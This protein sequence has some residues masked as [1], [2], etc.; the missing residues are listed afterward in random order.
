MRLS[1][2]VLFLLVSVA[3]AAAQPAV[4]EKSVTGDAGEVIVDVDARGRA[5]VSWVVQRKP[6]VGQQTDHTSRPGLMLDF[7]MRSDGTLTDLTSAIV[8]I[9]SYSDPE[10]G[11]APPL[12]SFRVRAKA[13][14]APIE[15]DADKPGSGEPLLA[16]RLKASWPD[17]IALELVDRKGAI[18]ASAAFDLTMRDDAIKLAREARAKCS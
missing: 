13:G 1:A 11:K 12:S 17:E 16:K 5:T 15:W 6:G 14:G 18:V 4:C 7:G 3:P 8:V 9:T 10:I 2:L